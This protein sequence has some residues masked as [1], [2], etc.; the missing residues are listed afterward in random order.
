M[1]EDR[2]RSRYDVLVR[3]Q[4]VWN[5]AGELRVRRF[6]L[7]ATCYLQ[8]ERHGR[9]GRRLHLPDLR[10]SDARADKNAQARDARAY[11]GFATVQSSPSPSRSLPDVSSCTSSTAFLPPS[12]TSSA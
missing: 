1:R 12:L 11:R 7:F 3:E 5:T 10:L 2:A 4:P 9:Q 6:T 8:R